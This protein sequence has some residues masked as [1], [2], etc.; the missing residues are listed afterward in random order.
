[1]MQ[2]RLR[3][4]SDIAAL[5]LPTPLRREGKPVIGCAAVARPMRNVLHT[6]HNPFPEETK[7]AH[8]DLKQTL[9]MAGKVLVAEGQD[10]FTRGHI[11][12]RAPKKPELFY[13]KPH[14]IAVHPSPKLAAAA[15][16]QCPAEG[17]Y[18]IEATVQPAHP[19]CGNGITWSLELRRGGPRQRLAVRTVRQQVPPLQL[20]ENVHWIRTRLPRI[21]HRPAST[22]PMASE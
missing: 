22:C 13:M 17:V 2:S 16:W 7:M 5:D 19:E 3:K 12:V 18:R 4:T 9:I 10:D 8:E 1:M 14:S 21:S 6:L 15:G 20:V 11:S